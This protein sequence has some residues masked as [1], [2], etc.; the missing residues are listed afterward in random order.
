MTAQG[1]FW[2]FGELFAITFNQMVIKW[3]MT[4]AN[5]DVILADLVT[6]EADCSAVQEVSA[7]KIQKGFGDKM[8]FFHIWAL[9]I[10]LGPTRWLTGWFV[11]EQVRRQHA[12]FTR[13]SEFL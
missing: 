5:A 3:P 4:A 1:V 7:R 10:I 6:I 13:L 8:T 12:L 9:A 2:L 11:H